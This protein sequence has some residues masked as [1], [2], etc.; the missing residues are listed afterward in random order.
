L[1]IAFAGT[2]NFAATVLRG[3]LS[4]AHQ[5]GLVI[6]QPDPRKG[7]GRKTVRTPVAE[8]AD[9]HHLALRQPAK[10]SEI[11]DELSSYDALVVAAYGQ[12]LRPDTL[13][14]T[15]H[16]AYNVHASLLPEYRGAAP[17][18]RAIMNGE[19]ETG[20]TIM[21]MDEGLDTGPIAL[22]R[23]VG[24]PPAMNAGELTDLLAEIGAEAVVESLDL[25][26]V[27][28]LKLHDQD[29]LH[30]TYASK[31]LDE[32]RIIEWSGGV[33]EVHDLIRALAPHIGARTFLTGV[34]GP[35]KIWRSAMLDT[36]DTG[37]E[38]GRIRAENGRITVNCGDGRLEVLEL[39]SPGGRRLAAREFLL[40]NPL[41][42]VFS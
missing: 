41:A 11:S 30:A 19:T 24:I 16:G 20:V 8:L 4:S 23:P 34:A 15:T 33:R 25:L 42:G 31:I 13:Y 9:S 29:N 27:D 21:R 14:A 6:S 37:E 12:I 28:A 39:Q 7:R 10:I 5:V 17:V 38:V 22:H 40:G 18:E 2:P 35:V 26:Q 1:R 36:E 32:D 3:L